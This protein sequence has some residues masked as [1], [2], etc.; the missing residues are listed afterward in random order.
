LHTASDEA[1]RWV[2]NQLL[3]KVYGEPVILPVSEDVYAIGLK[4]VWVQFDRPAQQFG[5][6]EALAGSLVSEIAAGDTPEVGQQLNPRVARR[7]TWLLARLANPA[8][9]ERLP[10]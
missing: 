9:T 5:V 10:V 7:F 4:L 6:F 8:E 2:G 3:Q 1:F